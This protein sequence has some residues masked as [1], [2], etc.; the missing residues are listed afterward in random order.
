MR[1]HPG[2]SR[3]A[4]APRSHGRAQRRTH[5]HGFHR[6]HRLSPGSHHRHIGRGAGGH[7]SGADLEQ[8]RG[9]GLRPSRSHLSAGGA[10]GR[11]AGP[12]RAYRG[13]HRPRRSGRSPPRGPA[14]GARQRRRHRAAPAGADGVC[15]RSRPEDRFHRRPHRLPADAGA[16]GGTDD[17][18]RG[19]DPDRRGQGRGLQDQVRGR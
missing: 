17:G 2:G 6:V 3:Q 14:G 1:A 18:V 16:A 19:A 11:R 13:G 15:R 7:R 4:A 9:G 8:R 10:P 5:E 12:V